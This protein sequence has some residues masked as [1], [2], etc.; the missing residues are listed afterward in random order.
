[1]QFRAEDH[2]AL[3][4]MYGFKLTVD[5][6]QPWAVPVLTKDYSID[7]MKIPITNKR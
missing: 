3:Q 6:A 7:D 1:M 4:S 5:A 2:Q